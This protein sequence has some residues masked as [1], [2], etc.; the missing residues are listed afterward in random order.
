MRR[1][2]EAAPDVVEAAVGEQFSGAEGYYVMERKG[3]AFVESRDEKMQRSLFERS[4]E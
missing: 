2:R 1:A 3:E 4:E